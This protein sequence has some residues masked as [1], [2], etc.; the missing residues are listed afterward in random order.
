MK[1]LSLLI[2]TFFSTIL[3]SQ[4][5]SA[6]KEKAEREKMKGNYA[7]A[8]NLYTVLIKAEPSDYTNFQ[9]RAL[10]YYQKGDYSKSI[11]DFNR[12]LA[13]RT[14]MVDKYYM[15]W[16]RGLDYYLLENWT[17][18]F[19]D[20]DSSSIYYYDKPELIG[21]KAMTL[22]KLAKHRES[23]RE[24]KSMLK[25]PG[26][27]REDSLEAYSMLGFS[28]LRLDSLP[29]SICYADNLF[30]IAPLSDSYLYLK[31]AVYNNQDSIQK[32]RDCYSAI[33]KLD[34]TDAHAYY[35]RGN[36]LNSLEF[37]NLAIKDLKKSLSMSENDLY[38]GNYQLGYSYSGLKKYDIAIIYYNKCLKIKP[39]SSD[40]H[41][42]IAW[43]YFLSKNYQEGLIHADKALKCDDKNSN[44]YDTRGAILYRLGKY[45]RA[46]KDFESALEI[47]SLCSNSYYFRALCYIKKHEKVKACSDLETVQKHKDY[48]ILA[49]ERP[50]EILVEEIC[51]NSGKI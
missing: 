15:L 37:Y 1:R 23:I 39:G 5:N 24:W 29:R 28:Y 27:T 50:I 35:C 16:I 20:L 7:S 41:N 3:F 33:I 40:V 30:K 12:A 9:N 21:A 43:M 19:K 49:G 25:I 17:E 8:I 38:S 22:Y 48:K 6:L 34:S 18:A 44:A 45:D 47:D 36:S 13:F 46:I 31:A 51:C 32:A 42:Q 4:E 26:I 2:F 14:D 11:T 10:C